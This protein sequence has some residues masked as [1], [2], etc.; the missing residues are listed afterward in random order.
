L[1]P[2]G[3]AGTEDQDV[4]R[5]SGARVYRL[6]RAASNFS[7]SAA[8]HSA[9]FS[10]GPRISGFSIRL[11]ACFLLVGERPAG[12]GGGFQFQVGEV[13]RRHG[14]NSAAGGCGASM[15]YLGWHGTG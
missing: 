3:G 11:A 9:V 10:T 6:L 1:A 5:H 8:A 12:T 15:Q 2:V 7:A 4:V 13:D 14:E